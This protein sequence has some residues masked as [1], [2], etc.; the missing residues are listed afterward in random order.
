M[1]TLYRKHRPQTF[2]E[3]VNQ[4]HIKTT[5]QHE[6]AAEKTAHAYLFCGPRGIGKT[7][8]ARVFTKAINCEKRLAGKFEPCNKCASCQE[9]NESRSLDIMEIDA[10]SHNGV[11]NVRENI[12]A[13][14][15][16]AP[17][18]LKYKVFIIDEVHMLSTS[19]FSAL[20]KT[21][22]EPP[23]HI[24]FILCTTEIH[25]V[26][27]TIISR[28]QRFDLKKIGVAEITK[29][30]EYIAKEEGV[31]INKAILEEIA[32]R[33]EGHMRDAESLLGQLL[34]VG[35]PAKAGE[36][37][38]ITEEEANL[39]IPRSDIHEIINLIG[40]LN[41]KDSGSAIRLVN[42][43]VD[44]G[45]E[46]KNFTDNAIETLRRVM[47]NK[48]NPALAE[49]L[50][51]GLGE[52]V[53]IELTEAAKD[54]ALPR[55]LTMLE[56][57]MEARNELKNSFITQLPLELAIVRIGL[58]VG[59]SEQPRGQVSSPA[60]APQGGASGKTAGGTGAKPA[61]PLKTES[62]GPILAI[63]EILGKWNEVLARVKKYNHSLSFILRVCEPRSRPGGAL[64]LA[65][66][67]K[68]H[69]D[70][71]DNPGIRAIVEKTLKEVYNT[72]LRV[73]A[74]IDEA[75]EVSQVETVGK[76]EQH[77]PVNGEN[78]KKGEDLPQGD[79]MSSILKTFGGRIVG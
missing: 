64:C 23:S 33:S 34:V 28:C 67:Y 44:E 18:R 53:E 5:L 69:K 55:I 57:L 56:E 6:I 77:I 38:E 63:E 39:I 27:T 51:L 30:L 16:V 50:S 29:K 14:A 42:K 11:D 45:I 72:P 36:S 1:T 3:V 25:K 43:L 35:G 78:K 40:Y 75:I 37:A 17:S 68:F 76:D 9:I 70:R 32:R 48:V 62:G 12:I 74:I 52:Q 24:V 41:K 31:K 19:A 46:L 58:G 71:I 59:I 66:K 10:A 47:L 13:S 21:I 61:G 49:N 7:T 54:L 73:E 26:P 2:G 65:F 8:L 4:N 20:L 22:E 79:I 15:R 60:A